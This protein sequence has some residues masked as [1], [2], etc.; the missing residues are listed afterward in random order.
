MDGEQPAQGLVVVRGAADGLPRR[1]PR[2]HIACAA[3]NRPQRAEPTVVRRP[4]PCCWPRSFLHLNDDCDVRVTKAV[5]ARIC[6]GQPSPFSSA[7]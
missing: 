7:Y 2:V 3:T 4:T 5:A 1:S 6:H